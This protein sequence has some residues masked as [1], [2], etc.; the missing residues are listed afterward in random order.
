MRV[1]CDTNV[2]I[3]ALLFPGGVP[4]KIIHTFFSGRFL[5]C[6]SPDILTELKRVLSKKFS[7]A[8]QKVEDSIH[9]VLRISELVYPTE[10]LNVVKKDPTDNRVLE[11]AVTAN[12]TYLI[13]GDRQHLLPLKSYQKIKLISPRDFAEEML[14]V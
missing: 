11:C 14:I 7:L 13:S 5:H 12:A 3:S 8:E 10:R 9:L 1:V 4:D 2:L 6:T